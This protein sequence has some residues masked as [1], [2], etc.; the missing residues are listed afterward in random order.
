MPRKLSKLR[1]VDVVTELR[2]WMAWAIAAFVPD[3]MRW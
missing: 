3:K 2:L 1:V